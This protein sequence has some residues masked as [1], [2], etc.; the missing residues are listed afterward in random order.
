[1]S[2]EIQRYSPA[3]IRSQALESIKKTLEEIDELHRAY[4]GEGSLRA[5]DEFYAKRAALFLTLEGKLEKMA[6]FGSGLRNRGSIK[7]MLEISTKS[8]LH[9]GEVARYADKVTGVA[10]AAN[11]IKKGLILARHWKWL[12]QA[13]PSTRLAL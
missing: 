3:W 8:Y 2:Y 11:F 4:L 1:M 5:R 13:S 10:S 6:A 7:R 12:L 9:T